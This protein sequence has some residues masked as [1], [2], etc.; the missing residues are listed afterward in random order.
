MQFDLPEHLHGGRTLCISLLEHKAERNAFG[1]Q[2]PRYMGI[3][4]MHLREKRG[5]V[6]VLHGIYPVKARLRMPSADQQ[7]IHRSRPAD[8]GDLL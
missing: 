2:V 1:L 7:V 8:T 5:H 4:Y 6:S 3:P